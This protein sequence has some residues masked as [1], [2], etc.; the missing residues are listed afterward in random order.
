[1]VVRKFPAALQDTITPTLL[2][3]HTQRQAN[4][5]SLGQK[6]N[7]Q[8]CKLGFG[9]PVFPAVENHAGKPLLFTEA[10]FP[11]YSL[12]I[13]LGETFEYVLYQIPAL[14]NLKEFCSAIPVE[15]RLIVPCDHYFQAEKYSELAS[16]LGR[17]FDVTILINP[18]NADS[19]GRPGRD[20]ADLGHAVSQLSGLNFIGYQI[21][22]TQVPHE[23]LSQ[24]FSALKDSLRCLKK[25]DLTTSKIYLH[26]S[27]LQF[28]YVLEQSWF[29]EL[30]NQASIQV[31]LEH[32]V[33]LLPN[34]Y[35]GQLQTDCCM[36]ARIISRPNSDQA[37]LDFG[38][39]HFGDHNP[40][41]HNLSLQGWHDAE[42][43]KLNTRSSLWKLG[44]TAMN[45]LLGDLV[46]VVWR[47][48]HIVG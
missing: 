14:P 16:T 39:H 6:S 13:S 7:C 17:S 35:Q 23:D 4:L 22:F 47:V 20:S 19:G 38:T 8:K 44:P 45:L 43:L 40:V 32:G 46:G 3:D 1:M 36:L 24:S 11:K 27:T 12:F 2:V 34:G 25:W 41:Q 42:L 15:A 33:M 10:T 37:M 30:V 29:E 9:G 5:K 21:P 31:S 28:E 18:G 48:E 26:Y